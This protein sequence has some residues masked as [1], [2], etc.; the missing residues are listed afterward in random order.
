[1]KRKKNDIKD[2]FNQ[3]DKEFL[4]KKERLPIPH[5]AVATKPEGKVA[6]D[7]RKN[8]KNAS[9]RILTRKEELL[10]YTVDRSQVDNVSTVFNL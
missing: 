10:Y 8:I 6:E 4:S 3:D 1:M 9:H 2:L 7:K 5:T